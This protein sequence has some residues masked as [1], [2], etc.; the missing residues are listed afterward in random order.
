M[1]GVGLS[2]GCAL[3][4]KTVNLATEAPGPM[5]PSFQAWALSSLFLRGTALAPAFW[6]DLEE[7]TRFLDSDG[8]KAGLGWSFQVERM[9]KGNG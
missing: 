1:V 5:V 9:S 6:L 7:E 3:E 8:K 2:I 4:R